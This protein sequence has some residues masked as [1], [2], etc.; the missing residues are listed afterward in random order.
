ME[1]H[2]L[3]RICGPHRDEMTGGWRKLHNEELRE[4]YSSASIIRMIQVE[5]NEMGVAC[6]TNGGEE[7]RI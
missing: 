4:F 6:S 3:R 5:E 7:E 2:G 1:E